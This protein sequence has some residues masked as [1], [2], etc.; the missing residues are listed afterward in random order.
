MAV[1]GR[2]QPRARCLAVRAV[3][4]TG[5]AGVESDRAF[6][7]KTPLDTFPPAAPTNLNGLPDAGTVGLRWAA[8]TASDLGG[9]LVLRGEGTGGT[10]QQLTPAPITATTYVDG[11]VRPGVTYTYVV[12]AVD[13]ST[14]PNVSTHSNV[15][16]VTIR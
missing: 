15:Y 10:L 6:T 16:T 8:V 5:V 4:V 2:V 9:Y 1:A 3:D 14:P 13:Q 7:C 12:V 11:T